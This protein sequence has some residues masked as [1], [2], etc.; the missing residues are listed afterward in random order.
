MANIYF[1]YIF[2]KNKIYYLTI[3]YKD[4]LLL[5][6]LSLLYVVSEIQDLLSK[7]HT[8]ESQS[9]LFTETPELSDIAW[10]HQLSET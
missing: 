7:L 5:F 2:I 4:F 1:N 3:I 10:P 9:F 6:R 8:I